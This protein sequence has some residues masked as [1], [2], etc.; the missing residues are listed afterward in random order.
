MIR[1]FPCDIINK[2]SRKIINSLS[3]LVTMEE[4]EFLKKKG[5]TCK[6]C[7]EPV[8]DFGNINMSRIDVDE[9]ICQKCYAKE[10]QVGPEHWFVDN[11]IEFKEWAD[12]IRSCPEGE[13]LLQRFKDDDRFMCDV[14][15]ERFEEKVYVSKIC[16]RCKKNYMAPDTTEKKHEYCVDCFGI[17]MGE[18]FEKASSCQIIEDGDNISFVFPPKKE[19]K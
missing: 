16:L 2:N 1:S 18:E 11:D 13:N 19:E 12:F 5:K 8:W 4:V 7:D 14:D 15:N 10:E 9:H 17:V 3:S 6:I